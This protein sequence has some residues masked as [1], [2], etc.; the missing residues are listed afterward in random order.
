MFI[1]DDAPPNFRVE[2][3]PSFAARAKALAGQRTRILYFYDLPDNS[4]F[5]YRVHNMIQVLRASMPDVA[6]SWFC[7]EDLDRMDEVL[8]GIAVLVLCRVRY[9]AAIAQ[10]VVRARAQ[11][12]RVFFDVDDFVF[13]ARHTNLIVETLAQPHTE[14]I[15]DHWFGYI[16]RIGGTLRLCDAVIVTNDYLAARVRDFCDLPCAVIPNFLNDEQLAVSAPIRDDKAR[17]GFSRDKTIHIGYFSGSPTHL[18]DFAIAEAAIDRIMTEDSRIRLR[19]VGYIAP[20]SR[21][22]KYADRIE[23]FPMQ[24]YRAL[25]H[26]IATTEIN[27]VPLQDNLF[28]NAKSELKVFE[29]AAVATIS[30]ASRSFT[31]SRAIEHGA[32]GF[33]AQPHE[34]ES[35]LRDAVATLDSGAY[36]TMADRAAQLALDR[37]SPSQQATAVREALFPDG[38][39]IH[40]PSMPPV[41]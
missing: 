24:D 25:Q 23:F 15:W 32:S 27:M 5:R 4:T 13:D 30:V 6:A 2:P 14:E 29:A 34:W 35:A 41:P 26:L 19:L 10:M 37:F 40:A 22:S 7:R 16:G 28:T 21:L 8:P 18:R 11:G 9:S 38:H 31:L 17:S 36:A 33:L 20:G 3:R 39:A 12:T 1:L